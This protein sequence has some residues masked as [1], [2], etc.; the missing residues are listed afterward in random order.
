MKKTKPGQ[1]KPQREI[2]KVPVHGPAI[3]LVIP[4]LEKLP[5]TVQARIVK[6][7]GQVMEKLNF[8]NVYRWNEDE[9]DSDDDSD[10]DEDEDDSDGKASVEMNDRPK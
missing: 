3:W 9:E 1:P 5:G 10:E 2:P 7:A 4:L 6:V 8:F